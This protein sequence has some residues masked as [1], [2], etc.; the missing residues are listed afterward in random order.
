M[1]NSTASGKANRTMITRYAVIVL[2]GFLTAGQGNSLEFY[3]TVSGL[4]LLVSQI[5]ASHAMAFKDE[6]TLARDLQ[7]IRGMAAEARKGAK[8]KRRATGK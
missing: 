5:E 6:L 8:G 1:K 4:I 2:T 3:F 7:E